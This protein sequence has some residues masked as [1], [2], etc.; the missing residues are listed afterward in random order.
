MAPLATRL[1]LSLA[2]AASLLAGCA[3]AP[4]Y[5]I[6]LKGGR[7]L[8]PASGLDAVRDVGIL[9]DSIAAISE[10]ALQGATVVDV[11]GLVVAPGFIDLHAHGQTPGDMA[12]QA[13]DGVTTAIDMET[14]AYPVAGW[15]KSMEGRARLNYGATVGHIPA[16]FAVLNGIEI[17]HW[18][19][20]PGPAAGLGPNPAGANRATTPAELEQ[21]ADALRRGLDEGALGIGF[22]I[23]YTPAASPAEITRLFQVGAERKAPV[24]VH[25]RAFGIGA[26]R[27]AITSAKEAGA[28]LH[29]VHIGSSASTEVP[30]ALALIDSV[31]AA[32]Q[33]VTTEVYPYTAGST[34]IES[35]MF[36]PGWQRNLRIDYGDLAW[37]ATGERLTKAT[38][39]KYRAQGGW[40]ILHMMKEENI[41]QAIRHPGVMIASDGV[42]FVNGSG[43]PRG[44][45]TFARVLGHYSRERQ[46]V[47]LVEAVRKMTQLPAQRLEA[48]VPAMKSKGRIAVGADAD[49]TVFDPDK[50]L[51]RATFTEPTVTSV[52]IPFVL[53]NGTFVV[54]D[55]ALVPDVTPGRPVLAKP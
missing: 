34:L 16:R 51:D 49:I 40:V 42:P 24:F 52:G 4:Q 21:L 12:F 38:F 50:V 2:V 27:E 36:N 17:G 41:E 45:G 23:N 9:G 44:A 1:T 19:T 11:T 22:G 53:V 10:K 30:V 18:P 48:Y 54:R 39:D 35:A 13:Q 47:P 43:H 37:A 29:I 6:V 33:D 25:T 8:D 28:S 55:G 14:G 15:Y 31:R 3:Q 26:I 46:V 5:D 32:G 20:N 7:V